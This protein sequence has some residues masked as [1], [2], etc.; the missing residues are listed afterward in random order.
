MQASQEHFK[1]MQKLGAN[2]VNYGKL[3]NRELTRLSFD[4]VELRNHETAN[5]EKFFDL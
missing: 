2:R 4:Q 1:T 5:S 3:E